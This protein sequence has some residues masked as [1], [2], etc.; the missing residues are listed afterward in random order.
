[1]QF[2]HRVKSFKNRLRFLFE[3]FLF[4]FY[5]SVVQ[6]AFIDFHPCQR[7]IQLKRI[8]RAD[9]TLDMKLFSFLRRISTGHTSDMD[10]SIKKKNRAQK[11]T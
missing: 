8:Q 1:M 9:R 11:K 2:G 4:L 10:F 3:Y 5:F 7:Q 6:S